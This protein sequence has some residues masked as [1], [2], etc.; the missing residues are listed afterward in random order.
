M[1]KAPQGHP[2]SNAMASDSLLLLEKVPEA[3]EAGEGNEG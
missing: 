3:D 2:L 1:N